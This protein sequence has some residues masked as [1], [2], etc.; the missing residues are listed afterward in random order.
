MKV[1]LYLA[2]DSPFYTNLYPSIKRGFEE[3][4]CEVEGDSNL[5]ESEKLIQKIEEFKPDFV[6]E[7]NRVK[8][9]IENFPTNVIHVCWL[10]DF[11]GR[12]HKELSGSN[13]LYTWAEDWIKYFEK[14][15]IESVLYLPPATDATIY[16]PLNIKKEYDFIFLGHFYADW[17][18]NRLNRII[19][20]YD[21]NKILLF[22]DILPCIKSH[23]LSKNK[24]ISF[25]DSLENRGMIL[26]KPIPNEILND[27][28][29][30]A[31]RQSVREHYIDIFLNTNTKLSIYGSIGWTLHDKYKDFYKG[32]IDN[33]NDI[34]IALS[35]SNIVLHDSTYL[36]FRTFD[37]M[38]A[39]VVVAAAKSPQ[40]IPCPWT[41]QGFKD[42]EDYLNIDIYDLDIDKSL[43][44]DI[45]LLQE[46]AKN[47]RKKVLESHLWV[48]RA[49]KIIEDVSNL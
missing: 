26:D 25:L 3:A 43:F 14:E 8:S 39:G 32:Y 10:V 44:N 29:S 17:G 38:V 4:G 1:L 47:A 19:G 24:T 11:W 30:R 37:A 5:L 35:K 12:T 27:I 20:H 7:M 16:K 46:I 33:F 13:I 28:S 22:K 49:M 9:E 18:E 41:K 21:N 48:H 15:G 42:K 40:N 36:H 2:S 45:D 34:N 31:Y 23:A 6:F